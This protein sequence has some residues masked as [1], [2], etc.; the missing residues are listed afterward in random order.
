MPQYRLAE[1]ALADKMQAEAGA[2]FVL[3]QQANETGDSY[4]RLTVIF[5]AVSFLAGICTRF[6]YPFHA[7]VV[8]LGFVMLLGG[9]IALV[10]QPVP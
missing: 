8:G 1:S 9:I 5:A 2:M 7:F 6:P 4:V 10:Q 3:A